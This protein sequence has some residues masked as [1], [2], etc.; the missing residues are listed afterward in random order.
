MNPQKSFQN[1]AEYRALDSRARDAVSKFYESP[2][3]NQLSDAHD[4][5][6]HCQEASI[7]FL[8]ALRDEGGN[9]KLVCWSG[10]GWYHVAVWI[11]GTDVVVDWTARQFDQPGDDPVEY[12]R[13]EEM[14]SAVERWGESIVLDPDTP[15]GRYVADLPE[16]PSW[17]IAQLP[18][19]DSSSDTSMQAQSPEGR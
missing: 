8:S 18:I 6:G 13:I 16:I 12:P 15:P 9:G 11:D 4:V 10:E 3:G 5:G 19:D 17:D 14:D 2:V 7:R 1:Q